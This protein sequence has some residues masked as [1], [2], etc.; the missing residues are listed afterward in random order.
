MIHWQENG[1]LDNFTQRQLNEITPYIKNHEYKENQLIIEEGEEGDRL[2]MIERG[3]VEI[4]KDDITLTHLITGQHFGVMALLDKSTRSANVKT[5][6]P[7][8]LKSIDL[9]AL[10]AL[11]DNAEDSIFF[12]ILQNHLHNQQDILRTM[13]VANIHETKQK[14]AEAKKNLS[15]S[16]FFLFTLGLLIFYMFIMGIF[17][18]W[19]ESIHTAFYLSC[20]VPLML[21]ILGI[22]AYR[23]T[24]NSGYPPA[25]FGISTAK[26]KADIK[27]SFIWTVP[28]LV[29]VTLVKWFQV[30]Y[31]EA[32]QG[33]SIIDLDRIFQHDLKWVLLFFGLY[34]LFCPIQ[35]FITRGVYQTGLK[36]LFTGKQATFRAILLSNLLFSSFHLLFNLYF[37][38]ITLIPGIFWGYLY[39][40]QKTLV[41]VSFSHILIGLY[42]SFLGF[43]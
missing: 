25:F 27:E 8:Q 24:Q 36:N 12:K 9:K 7:T 38:F 35:E 43:H 11:S 21:T 41:G 30:Q 37:A 20:A 3:T 33:E 31:V 28:F 22:A 32:Y 42:T 17:L 29:L 18:E 16:S 4:Y 5:V 2:Y 1:L 15:F 39:D 40:R 34:V 23:Y 19:K 6:T 26:W 14:L 10:K 13:N